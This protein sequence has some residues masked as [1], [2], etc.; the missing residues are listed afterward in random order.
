MTTA[1]SSGLPHGIQA[2]R[3]PYPKPVSLAK[4]PR[5]APVI[6]LTSAGSGADRLLSLLDRHPEL[7]C[8]S[9]TGILP[10]CEQAAAVWRKADGQADGPL[11]A[12][13]AASARALASGIITSMLARDGK[14]RWCEVATAAPRTAETFLQLYPETSVVCLHRACPDV[15]RAILRASPWGIAGP[16]FAP[17]VRA[18]PAST[19]AALAGYWAAQTG[20]LLAFERAHPQV[21]LR[22][23]YEDLATAPDDTIEKIAFF[24]GIGDVGGIGRQALPR[25]EHVTVAAS[26]PGDPVP[27]SPLP[28]E[29]IPP[30]LLARVN[31]LLQ[32]LDYPPLR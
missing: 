25:A 21:C 22:V 15:V 4:A 6:V 5:T 32:Q 8:T 30:A 13:A 2:A 7:S 28:A 1:R 9:G 23:R 11:S 19:V 29:Q 16:V 27:Q 26:E 14:R 17:Y 3:R 12:L 24:G 31:D 20:D 10:L 18:H